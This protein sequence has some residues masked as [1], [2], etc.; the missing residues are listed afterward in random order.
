MYCCSRVCIWSESKID[1]KLFKSWPNWF[2]FRTIGHPEEI[3]QQIALYLRKRPELKA[4][5]IAAPL[6]EAKLIENI[7]KE[8]NGEFPI[9]TGET[10]LQYMFDT[11]PNCQWM[12]V[13]LNPISIWGTSNLSDQLKTLPDQLKISPN[14]VCSTDPKTAKLGLTKYFRTIFTISSAV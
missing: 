6:E 11:Y 10:L 3:A 1:P 12:K 4:L 8:L 9:F 13:W 2:F 14:R 5:Y 7:R